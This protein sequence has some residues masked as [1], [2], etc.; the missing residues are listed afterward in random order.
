L[1]AYFIFFSGIN[2]KNASK[3][4][5]MF[6][7]KNKDSLPPF[8]SSILMAENATV[9]NKDYGPLFGTGSVQSGH[10]L[11]ISA[12]PVLQ[13]CY[14]DLG[15][16]YK[17]PDGYVKGSEKARCLLAGR[18]YFTPSEIEVFCHKKN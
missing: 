16:A 18:F 6:S 15:N 12:N 4:A 10:D 8:K 7:L 3:N 2:R 13:N 11:F 5:F 1:L 14:C 17:L 9:T